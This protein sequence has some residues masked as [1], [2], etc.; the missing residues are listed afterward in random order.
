MC[1]QCSFQHGVICSRIQSM[2]DLD[3]VAFRRQSIWSIGGYTILPAGA[4]RWNSEA[5]TLEDSIGLIGGG[6]PT[7]PVFSE[8]LLVALRLALLDV[9][10]DEKFR[11]SSASRTLTEGFYATFGARRPTSRRTC[12]PSCDLIEHYRLYWCARC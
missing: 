5:V 12:W 2:P 11:A 1:L 8:A 6:S 9:M 3:S 4:M 7:A 10:W